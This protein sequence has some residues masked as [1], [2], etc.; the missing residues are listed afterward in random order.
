MRA[1]PNLKVEPYRV[2][3][4]P[5]ASDISYGN[6]GCFIIPGPDRGKFLTVIVSDGLSWEHVSV[7]TKSRIP[8]WTEM[9][10]IKNIFWDEEECVIQFHPPRSRYINCHPY[11]LHLWKP[12]GVA[13]PMPRL[14]MV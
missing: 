12:V 13:L 2:T 3:H 10:F 7:S 11:V 5:K 8:T 9:C 4:G 1:I 14:E 6:N